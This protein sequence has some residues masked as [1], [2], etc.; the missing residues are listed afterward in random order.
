MA[1]LMLG[2]G[3]FAGLLYGMLAHHNGSILPGMLVHFLGDLAIP[4][5]VL[6][7]TGGC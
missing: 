1:M 6:G 7:A 4:T 5:G 2:P 3:T